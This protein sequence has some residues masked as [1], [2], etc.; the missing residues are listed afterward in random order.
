MVSSVTV[1][2]SDNTSLTL[3]FD[4]SANF[5]LAQQIAARINASVAGGGLVTAFD[6]AG[7][8]PLVEPGHK[9]G[10]YQVATNFVIMPP[11]YTVDLVKTPGPAVV[12]GSGAKN[13]MIMSDI[14]TDLTFIA[15][16]GSGSV[17]AGGGNSLLVVPGYDKGNWA[18]FTGN[19]NDAI[20]AGGGHNSIVLGSGHD[21]ITSTGADTI[22]G[23]TG[24]ETVNALKAKSDLIQ[25]GD[26][27]LLFIGGLGGATIL[28]G[29]GS[30]TYFGSFT[31]P[32]GNQLV[33]GGSKGHNYLFA[34]NGAATLIGGG[35]GDQLFAVGSHDQT[36]I[37]GRG[38]ETLSA[39]L[40]S[41][42]D[43][44]AAG[45]GRDLLI[46]GT[47]SD[48]FVG[49]SGH[50]TVQS[51]FTSNTFEFIN[52]ESGGTQLVTNIFDPSSIRIDLD[53]YGPGAV[54]KA[55]QSQT[56][57]D[58]S[59]TITLTDGTRVTFEDVTSL[60]RNNFV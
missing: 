50:S 36:L 54:H 46:G 59:V 27:K 10:Y 25:G 45:S 28:G 1:N 12:I 24:S 30:D 49:G 41:G 6:T 31:G 17:V 15:T 56:V 53:G 40:S 22:Y 52:H 39:A 21:I 42:N 18:L 7:P 37:A 11:D 3:R 33:K 9:G 35:K 60:N 58:G 55:L 44:I 5:T 8:P 29:E 26:S 47:G 34:G 14:N 32:V 4:S 48:T 51:G 2:G 38:N 20:V 43:S 16:G 13:E 57:H 23:G 19:G